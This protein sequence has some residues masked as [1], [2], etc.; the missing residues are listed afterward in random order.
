MAVNRRFIRPGIS[1]ALLP[2]RGWDPHVDKADR[3]HAAAQQ[4]LQRGVACR[5]S[6]KSE[7]NDEREGSAEGY[8]GPGLDG[9]D[10]GGGGG[11]ADFRAAGVERGLGDFFRCA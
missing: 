5:E 11:E 6:R 1:T 3:E 10:D 4:P 9:L 7:A 8:E 2:G